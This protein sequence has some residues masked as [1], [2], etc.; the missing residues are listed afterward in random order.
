MDLKE[1]IISQLK[2]CMIIIMANAN[3]YTKWGAMEAIGG[4]EG[5]IGRK[6]MKLGKF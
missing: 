1:R 6:Q 5:A 2:A 3:L 4:G